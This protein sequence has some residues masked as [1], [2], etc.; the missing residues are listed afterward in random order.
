[1]SPNETQQQRRDT[2]PAVGYSSVPLWLIVFLGLVFYWGL[3]YVNDNGGGFNSRVYAPNKNFGEVDDKQPKSGDQM[4][5]IKG[6]KV[7]DAT[8]SL[9][10]QPNGLGDPSKAPPL[11]GSEWV[12]APKPDRIIRIVLDGFQGPVT[13]KGQDF[14]LAMASWKSTF[15]DDEI[16]AVLSYVRNNWNN[17]ASMVKPE[18]VAEI[19]A[20]TKDRTSSWTS[21]ELQAVP[22][23]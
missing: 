6:K 17:K 20:K 23:R 18:Q 11:V 8:C 2:E 16:A 9:C 10:H 12:L 21:P 22:D 15:K 3:M 1:M 13:V 4:V 5:L 7:Y 19:R 14:N